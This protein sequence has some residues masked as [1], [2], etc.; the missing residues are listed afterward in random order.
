MIIG[1]QA[2]FSCRWWAGYGLGS[3]VIAHWSNIAAMNSLA[4]MGGSVYAT[5]HR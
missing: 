5:N 3:P 1:V 2:S 4:T